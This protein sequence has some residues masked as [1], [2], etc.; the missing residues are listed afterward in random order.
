M[1]RMTTPSQ[2]GARLSISC[3]QCGFQTGRR[4]AVC[5]AAGRS[6]G[7]EGDITAAYVAVVYAGVVLAR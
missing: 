2:S 6:V 1:R 3:L 7:G 4:R 5:A